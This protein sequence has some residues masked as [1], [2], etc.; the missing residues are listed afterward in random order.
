MTDRILSRDP[1]PIKRP[2]QERS[3]LRYEAILDCAERM[4]MEVDAPEI[5]IHMIAAEASIPPASIYHFFPDAHL[6]F[7]GLAERY[8]AGMAQEPQ[9]PVPD[10][11]DSWQAFQD[12]KFSQSRAWF[13]ANKPGCKILL[14]GP[15]PSREIQALDLAYAYIFAEKAIET[16]KHL[17]VVPDVPNLLERSVEVI[18][19][20]KSIWALSV[21]R[22]GSITDEMEE[23]AR[24]A[25]IAY[26]RTYLP[27]Y[28]ELRPTTD[29]SE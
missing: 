7:V 2:S 1:A 13:N 23:Q 5:S 17:F 28:L 27:E 20:N 18:A 16:L 14:S 12:W 15:M 26:S 4:L 29:A 9:T 21:H 22:H 11:I 24:R 3:R 25:R 6:I 19:I 10:G 8:L